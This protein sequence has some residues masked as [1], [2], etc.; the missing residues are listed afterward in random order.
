MI[1]TL[2]AVGLLA[3][4]GAVAPAY[5]QSGSSLTGTVLSEERV[6]VARAIVTV[7]GNGVRLIRR[8]DERGR[9]AFE[10]LPVGTYRVSA[11]AATG[12]AYATVDLPSAG[13]DVTL[14]LLKTVGN[15]SAV[16]VPV[17]RGSGTDVVLNQTSI[18]H[19]P[20]YASL[21]DLL[22][23][24]PGAAR[25]A[26]GVV[27]INGDHGDINYVVDGVPIP[28]ALNREI[29][30][31][32]DPADISFMDV[33]EGAYPAQYGGRFA[34]VV[35]IDTKAASGPSALSGYV[36]GG[37]Y[38]SYDSDF[39]YHTP[40]GKGS[41]VLAV[42]QE[43]TSR[44]LDP[45]TF[46]AVHDAGSDLNQFARYAIPLGNDFLLAS[47]SHSY[48]TFAI[49][50]DVE[51]GEPAATDDNEMQDDTFANV[52]YH[53]TL[54]SNGA[55]T[56]GIAFK[57]SR[58]RDTNDPSNDFAYG[59]AIN[60]S[61]GG[62][63]S[64][65]ASGIVS[66]CAYSLFSDRTAR[67][68]ILNVDSG[69]RSQ[70]HAVR[71]GA[72]YDAT[73]V[74]KVY[75]V[76]LQPQNFISAAAA[77]V[78]DSAPNIAHSENAYLQ[79]SWQ[80][81]LL[82][83]V[84]YGVRLDAFQIN[85]SQ[86]ARGFS[87]ASPRV[88]I[89]RVYGS[90]ADFY[91][92]AGRFFTPFSFENVS[93]AAA[94]QLNA[95]LQP[96]VAQFDLKP[97]RD[98]DVEVGGS[99]PLAAGQLGIRFIQKSAVDL[100]DDTQVGVTALHQ[101]INYARGNISSQSAYYQQPLRRSGRVYLSLTHTRSVNKGCETQLLAPCFG[102]P[103]DWTP[104]DHDQRWDASGGITVNDARGGW[105]TIQGKYGSGLSSAYCLPVDEG[106]KVPPHTTF[107]LQK[108]VA[109]SNNMILTLGVHNIF[110]DRYRITY[111]NA[112]GNHYDAGRTFS[113]GLRFANK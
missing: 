66:A 25:G 59:E 40:L 61:S 109:L 44:A 58:I 71:Y 10:A 91:V 35:N 24:L 37:S 55:I 86:F 88:K 68:L 32:I 82:W 105:L 101:D 19:S 75:A 45:P 83:R 53:H 20:A 49:P 98:T 31:E 26:N 6:A 41:L 33:L 97:Q 112:Q 52:Q 79:D 51:G 43:R 103:D 29:G 73:Q 23:Q 87:Q 30:S 77:T 21:P 100:I 69:V 57:R 7:S 102:A 67:D 54:R 34:A 104:A 111:L 3:P 18:S 36:S 113:M 13:V 56:Y 76:T 106:C 50:N 108:G 38:A 11:A 28:Q 62:S 42:R 14:R 1:L 46:T 96:G 63:P 92:Y 90:H 22:L 47:V 2:A 60:V 95:P 4:F 72:A 9:F 84:D 17:T 8:T 5:A 78:V 94:Q 93:P 74:A 110:N 65:C 64:D 81:G 70:H 15:T 27:H 12:N 107:D 16:A 85:S 99:M 39:D 48:Q 89:T 80:M